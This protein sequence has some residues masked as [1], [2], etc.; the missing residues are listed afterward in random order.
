MTT[1]GGKGSIFHIARTALL[2]VYP[3]NDFLSPKC[4]LWPMVAML[5]LPPST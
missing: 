1:I 5:T 4:K 3:Y 2:F